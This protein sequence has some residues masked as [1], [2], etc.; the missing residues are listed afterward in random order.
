MNSHFAQ[1]VVAQ[2]SVQIAE[3]I[4]TANCGSHVRCGRRQSMPSNNIDSCARVN[5]T[6][7]S[8]ARGQTNFPRSRRL[9][10]KHSP[11]P[12]NQISFTRSPRRPRKM[13]TWPD[14]GLFSNLVCTSALSPV[15][16]RRKSVTPAA[17]QI[18]VLAGGPIIASDIATLP[19]PAQDPH[20]LPLALVHPAA[21]YKSCPQSLRPERGRPSLAVAYPPR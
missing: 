9:Q 5:E 17:I 12:S 10:N 2:K 14:I 21:G 13:N 3:C 19:A 11:S 7:P 15:K 8:V 20:S 4:Y 18:C 6:T 1:R 16:P